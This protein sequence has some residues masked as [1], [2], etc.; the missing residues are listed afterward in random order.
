ME[1]TQAIALVKTL[2]SWGVAMLDYNEN[3]VDILENAAG[4]NPKKSFT[5]TSC[6]THKSTSISFAELLLEAKK[7]AAVIQS[8]AEVGGQVILLFSPGIH[9]ISAFYGCILSGVISIP[10][11]PPFNV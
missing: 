3:L 9:F 10:L 7:I 6:D 8:K 1:T 4:E 5:F 2:W 11:P